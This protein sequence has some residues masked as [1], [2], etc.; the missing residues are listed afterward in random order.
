MG[1]ITVHVSFSMADLT[2][3]KQQ[4]EQY[5]K[6]PSQFMEGF[7]QLSIMFDLTWQDIYIILIHYCTP[8]EKNCIWAGAQEFAEELAAGDRDNYPVGGTAVPNTESHRNYQKEGKG[9]TRPQS[10]VE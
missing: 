7:Q 9:K 4:L 6:N 1:T 3:I 2:Q 10:P 8:E 5:S